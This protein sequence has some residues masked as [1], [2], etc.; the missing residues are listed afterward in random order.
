MST[1]SET[2]RVRTLKKNLEV[3]LGHLVLL[4]NSSCHTPKLKIVVV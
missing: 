1:G 4:E 3:G 2:D